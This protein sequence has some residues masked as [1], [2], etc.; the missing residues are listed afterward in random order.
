MFTT[1]FFIDTVQSSKKTFVNT[2]VQHETAKK[3]MTD[4]I[5]SQTAYTKAAAKA[6]MDIGTTMTS[7]AV[8]QFTDMTKLDWSKFDLAKMFNPAK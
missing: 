1:D 5:D 8:K 2:F 7:E 3:A 6:A 4:F